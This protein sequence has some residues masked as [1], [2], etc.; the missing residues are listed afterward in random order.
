MG[1]TFRG[2]RVL[3]E[4]PPISIRFSL[5]MMRSRLRNSSKDPSEF[6]ASPLGQSIS[7]LVLIVFSAAMFILER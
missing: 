3:L 2:N 4:D 1:E 7:A 5:S 6:A